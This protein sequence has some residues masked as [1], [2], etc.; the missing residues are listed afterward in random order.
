[1]NADA[2]GYLDAVDANGMEAALPVVCLLKRLSASHDALRQ[3][4]Q[5][6]ILCFLEV[7]KD[8]PL[9]QLAADDVGEAIRAAKQA[10]E[11]QRGQRIL[12]VTLLHIG[13]AVV[14]FP[15]A[16]RVDLLD[17]QART[18]WSSDSRERSRATRRRGRGDG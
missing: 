5:R 18:I 11:A 7:V 16:G 14:M 6:E 10:A 1:M 15:D 2:P 4:S 17:R 13:S 3:F 12:D 9:A 8:K